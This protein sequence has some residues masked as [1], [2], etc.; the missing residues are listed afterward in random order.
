MFYYLHLTR[1]PP[2]AAH[3]TQPLHITPNIAN[4]LRTEFPTSLQG[5]IDIY[6]AWVKS[7]AATESRAKKLMTWTGNS[8][9]EVL[10]FPPKD[11]REGEL[12]QLLLG[13]KHIHSGK[14]QAS[15]DLAPCRKDNGAE[16]VGFGTHVLPI[17]STPVLFTSQKSPAGKT[18]V[19]KKQA[20]NE[21]ILKLPP[22]WGAA[23]GPLR[24]TEHLSYDLD[25]KVWDS[26]LGLSYWLVSTFTG[27]G[28]TPSFVKRLMEDKAPRI[29]ELGAGTGLVSIVLSALLNHYPGGSCA[30]IT[31]TD[32]ESAM[33]VLDGNIRDNAQWLPSVLPR[34]VV[35]DW[36]DEVL[37]VEVW[38]G[39]DLIIMADVTYNTDSFPALMGTLSRL[40]KLRPGRSP[41]VLLAYKER[42]PDERRLWE[43]AR[44][45]G[46]RFDEI[47]HVG[48]AGGNPVEIYLGTFH[49]DVSQNTTGPA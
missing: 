4:D 6:Y 20:K 38:D 35:L 13:T 48:G 43:M 15:V 21:R 40:S 42:H 28:D 41:A 24:I 49:H 37:P 3:I 11:T 46:L 22:L 17:L 29:L 2:E 23:V 5:G 39:V 9:K 12:W 30:N 45:I 7:A 31:T 33:E 34:A 8:Y 47:A 19:D 32:L 14:F 36:D 26:G 1:P 18:S 27:E 10:V 16:L 25:K 44:A